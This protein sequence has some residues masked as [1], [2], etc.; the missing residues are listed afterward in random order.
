MAIGRNFDFIV[1]K[2]E[3]YLHVGNTNIVLILILL[4]LY[5][6]VIVKIL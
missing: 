1:K 6:D 4:V 5:I 3:L 2:Q